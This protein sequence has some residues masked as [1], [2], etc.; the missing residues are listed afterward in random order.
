MAIFT[1]RGCFIQK[2]YQIVFCL[3]L[4][5]GTALAGKAKK[6]EYPLYQGEDCTL[7]GGHP[8]G[9]EDL[10]YQDEYCAHIVCEEPGLCAPHGGVY[11]YELPP[12]DYGG[13]QIVVNYPGGSTAL[14]RKD[15]GAMTWGDIEGSLEEREDI[16]HRLVSGVR[17]IHA[18]G[19]G[20]AVLK[21]DGTLIAWRKSRDIIVQ[22]MDN[23][24]S[25]LDSGVDRIFSGPGGF[26]ALTRNGSVVAW[27]GDDSGSEGWKISQVESSD[28]Q[29][30]VINEGAWAVL[31]KDGSVVTWGDKDHG[32]ELGSLR[33]K[34]QN[35]VSIYSTRSAFAALRADDSVI[36]WG[37]PSTGGD[38]RRVSDL[39]VKVVDIV[40]TNNA[41]AI[42]RSNGF[43]VT[44]G[45][46]GKIF[47]LQTNVKKLV[48]SRG[49][50]FAA[51]KF[52]NSVVTWGAP[53]YGGDASSVVSGLQYDVEDIVANYSGFAVLKKD[54]SVLSWGEHVVTDET[55]EKMSPYLVA[56][57][58]DNP[59]RIMA[60]TSSSFSNAFFATRRDGSFI[61]W[62]RGAYPYHD[63]FHDVLDDPVWS[64]VYPDLE[65]VHYFGIPPKKRH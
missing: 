37:N 9:W 23:I 50:A 16:R 57:E 44:W 51:L 20:F 39:L 63:V 32:G 22:D 40:S 30:I 47:P 12:L 13:V 43:V 52:N 53:L 54:G 6:V 58:E 64:K 61:S 19:K 62:G 38:S 59:K 35:V 42:R 49:G 4:G 25:D 60:I 55:L 15:G 29:D 46:I 8:T 14:L 24:A 27:R 28:V 48:A 3:F 56:R 36:S 10:G 31:K 2:F 26:V 17:E 21:K 7:G 18:S 5:M 11:V 65:Y 41:F 34:L 33:H 45:K 1:F